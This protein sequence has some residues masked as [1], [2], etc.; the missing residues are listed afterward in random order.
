MTDTTVLHAL[1]VS[2]P[3]PTDLAEVAKA[4]GEHSELLEAARQVQKRRDN[5][6][7][8]LTRALSKEEIAVMEDRG[9]RAD[10]WALVTVAQDFDAFRVRRSHFKGTC[11]LGRF[12][13]RGRGAAGREARRPASTAAR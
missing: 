13:R 11:V 5:V 12:A 9:C 2:G 3:V 7:G 4:I 10:D 6:L 1:K 8:L